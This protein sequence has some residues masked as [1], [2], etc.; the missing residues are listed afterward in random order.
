LVES[1]GAQ[2]DGDAEVVEADDGSWTGTVV[3]RHGDNWAPG[4]VTVWLLDEPRAGETSRA[5][6][7]E[8]IDGIGD[9]IAMTL[10]GQSAFGLDRQLVP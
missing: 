1:H 2:V 7:N 6:V 4:R 9:P 5:V 10:R 3:L 8:T